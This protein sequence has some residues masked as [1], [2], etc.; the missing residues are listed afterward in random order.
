[1]T[2]KETT[3]AAPPQPTARE[4]SATT[5]DAPPVVAFVGNPNVGKTTLFNALTGSR[6]RVGNYPGITVE[7]READLTLPSG[8]KAI[9][10]DVPGTYSFVARTGEEQVAIAAT[11]GLK[12]QARPDV[13]VVCVDASQLER[14]CYLVLQALE[15][16]LPVVVAVTMIDETPN[17]VP[18]PRALSK[19]LGC[20]AVAVSARKGKGL[21]QLLKTIDERRHRPLQP[22][23]HW[24]PSTSLTEHLNRVRAH[25]PEHWPQSHAMALWALMSVDNQDELS[26]IPD[27]LREA[28]TLPDDAARAVD[29]EAIGARY[30]WIDAHLGPLVAQTHA[31]SLTLSRT[32][33]LDRLLIHPATGLPIFAAVMFAVFQALFAGADPFIAGIEQIF[34]FV[35]DE[36]RALLPQGLVNDFLTQG[37]IAGVGAIVV[38]L[39]QILMLFFFLGVLE[40]SGYMARVAVMVDRLMRTMNL[41]GRAFVPLLSGF[42]CAVPAIMAT[43]TMERQRDRLLTMLVIPLTT[44]SARLPVYSLIIVALFPAQQIFGFIPVRGLL[45]VAMYLFGIVMALLVA[46]ILSRTLKPLRARR[47]PFVLELPPYRLPRFR[48]VARMMRS[49]T[50]SFLNDAGRVILAGSIVLWVLLSFPRHHESAELLKVS[51]AAEAAATQNESTPA[52]ERNTSKK[53][54]ATREAAALEHSYA[55]RLGRALTPIWAPLG[56]DWK[57]GV[58]IIGAFAAREVFVATMGVVYGVGADVD[59]ESVPLRDKM[60]RARHPD[61]R[62]VYTPLVGLTLMIFFALSCQCMSTLAVVKRET[63]SW[64]WPVFLFV[65]M[66]S[67]AYVASLLVYQGGRLLGFGGAG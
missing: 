63:Q 55:G 3:A 50:V 1:V 41:H 62:P 11:L 31:R 35:T 28:A 39:P 53:L 26:D 49:R 42:A 25:L 45:M 36:L 67:L 2:T 22:I 52:L 7:R 58:G 14:G 24:Q 60:S 16:S 61:G 57:I 48:D 33:R 34:G 13:V 54:S 21:H 8:Q 10:V 5:S 12:G 29:D 59:E 6:A 30:R 44:C 46:W 9:A 47:L 64:R 65:Y 32:A 27:T 18:D 40:D 38:F 19:T 23:F 43:R 37:V 15:L 56:F 66:T 17:A 20:D 51:T 4:E